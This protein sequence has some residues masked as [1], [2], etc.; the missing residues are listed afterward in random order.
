MGKKIFVSNDK[1]TGDIINLRKYAWDYFALHSSQRLTTFYY[2]LIISTI[3]VS[4]Y[5]VSIKEIPFLSL[6]L[7]FILIVL[8][9]IFW[10][11]DIRTRQMIKNAEAALKFLESK[12]QDV[13]KE[14]NPCVLDIF[15]YEEMQ[16]KKLRS[17]NTLL[18]WK[19]F[20]SYSICLN[21][22]FLFLDSLELLVLFGQ[23]YSLATNRNSNLSGNT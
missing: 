12:D 23:Q 4:G 20:L 10:K 14:G 3:I 19:F 22:V 2:C 6:T 8:S 18:P 1:S 5:F 11:W 21:V 17:E 9:F 16:T 13:I 7:A 15:I